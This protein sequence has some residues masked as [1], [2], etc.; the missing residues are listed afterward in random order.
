MQ[1][2]LSHKHMGIGKMKKLFLS[3]AIMLLTTVY[4]FG[5]SYEPKYSEKINRYSTGVF[6]VTEKV[7]VYD[8]PSD[9]SQI[10]DVI[11]ID[12]IKEKVRTNTGE[13][14]FHSVFTTFST[15]KNLY[16]IT[17]IDE[18]Q[19]WVKLCYDNKTGWVK[20]EENYYIWKDFLFQYGKENGLYFFRNAKPENMALYQKP[21]ETSKKIASFDYARP[22]FLKLIRGS[23]ALASMS[24]FGDDSYVIGWIRWRNQDGSFILF[25]HI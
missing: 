7:T 18:A 4:A 17:V 24:D 9:T 20:A 2:L 21:D 1:L 15:D 5:A 6:A 13:T 25:P 8:E 12:K 16:F 23:W 22:V 14:S 11:E 3:L 10:I 19:D